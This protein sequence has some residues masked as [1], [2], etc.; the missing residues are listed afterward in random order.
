MA[1]GDVL[2][3]LL[4]K[5]AVT[6]DKDQADDGRDSRYKE[7][8]ARTQFRIFTPISDKGFFTWTPKGPQKS[9][10]KVAS[11]EEIQS[12]IQTSG[13]PPKLV[14]LSRLSLPQAFRTLPPDKKDNT[15]PYGQLD[16]AAL[17]VAAKHRGVKWTDIDFAFGGSTLEM[18]ANQDATGPFLAT[19]VPG[20]TTIMVVKRKSYF[21]D[22]SEIGFQFE[23]L[24][25]GQAMDAADS[26]EFTEHLHVMKV[27]EYQVLF[28][29]E[30]DAI[31]QPGSASVEVKA[32]NP[33]Y[34]GTRVM[35]QMISNGSPDLCHGV[36]GRGQ[37]RQINMRSLS[38]VTADALREHDVCSLEENILN[39]MKSLKDQMENAKANQVFKVSFS[40]GSLKLQPTR[41]DEFALL[42]AEDIVKELIL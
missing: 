31:K 3:D 1:T 33:Q 8:L 42:P 11:T 9:L 30:A 5:L 7:E 40:G 22:R 32:S 4:K 18:L 29:A 16:I 15:F 39:G 28:R 10:D 17:H 20:T 21:H 14:P 19:V 37:L 6:E 12:C 36:K 41:R 25:T 23:R 35:F 24:V 2:S 27:G 13:M 38:N 26:W 34:W